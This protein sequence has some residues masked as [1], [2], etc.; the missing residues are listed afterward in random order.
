[1]TEADTLSFIRLDP[2]ERGKVEA[3]SSACVTKGEHHTA[4]KQG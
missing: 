4:V 3:Q 1:M 2:G